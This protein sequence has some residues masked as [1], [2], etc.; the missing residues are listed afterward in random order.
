MKTWKK[1]VVREVNCG[2]EINCYVSGEF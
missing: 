2:A 1:P